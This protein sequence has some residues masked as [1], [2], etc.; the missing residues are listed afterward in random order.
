MI[1]RQLGIRLGSLGQVPGW[2]GAAMFS[3][4]P[5]VAQTEAMPA[6]CAAAGGEVIK[7]EPPDAAHGLVVGRPA[8]V[9]R[10]LDEHVRRAGPR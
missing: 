3:P 6:R 2:P 8:V 7:A 9:G 5:Q 10:L 1:K 4:Q